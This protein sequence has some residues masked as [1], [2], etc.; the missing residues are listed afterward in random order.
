[1]VDSIIC[2]RR[3][4]GCRYPTS[5]RSDACL[6]WC[7]QRQ[8]SGF[9][10]NPFTIFSFFLSSHETSIENESSPPSSS[11]S[12]NDISLS[13]SSIIRRFRGHGLNGAPVSF[14]YRRGSVSNWQWEKAKGAVSRAQ[15]GGF[16]V[17]RSSRFLLYI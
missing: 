12:R 6:M 17:L 10:V 16:L 2:C 13:L 8:Q 15:Q 5:I 1:M 14:Q 4:I 11:S 7:S 9:A 3:Y